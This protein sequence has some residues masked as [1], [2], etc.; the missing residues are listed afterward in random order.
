VYAIAIEDQL[1]PG[2]QRD[3]A[4]VAQRGRIVADLD[5]G[6]RAAVDVCDVSTTGGQVYA[7]AGTSDPP[8]AG[9][10]VGLLVAACLG[11]ALMVGGVLRLRSRSPKDPAP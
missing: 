3:I 2:T 9:P 11:I 4:Q 10:P 7:A 8:A 1:A 5:I 6:C